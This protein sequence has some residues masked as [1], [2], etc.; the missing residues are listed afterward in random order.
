MKLQG[1]SRYIFN[2]FFRN[3]LLDY[4]PFLLKTRAYSSV[5]CFL[6]APNTVLKIWVNVPTRLRLKQHIA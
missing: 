6:P 1:A 5:K 4:K 2:S 3:I